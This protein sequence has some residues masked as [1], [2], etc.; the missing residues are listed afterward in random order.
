[1][2]FTTQEVRTFM[3]LSTVYSFELPFYMCF[4]LWQ[5]L[6]ILLCAESYYIA[7]LCIVHSQYLKEKVHLE[8]LISQSKF[9]GPK[10]LFFRL[11]TIVVDMREFFEK[12]VAL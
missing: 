11:R 9:S 7:R 3:E 10:K 5:C 8:E 1:M 4:V 2:Y 12:S 6:H